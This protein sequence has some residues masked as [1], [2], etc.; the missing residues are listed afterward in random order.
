[1]KKLIWSIM[2]GIA[3]LALSGCGHCHNWQE[4][5]CVSSKLCLEC[6]E[7]QGT[8]T[9]HIWQDATCRTPKTC[10]YCGETDGAPLE[11]IWKAATCTSPKMCA[12]CETT[13]GVPLAHEWQEASCTDPMLCKLCG[14]TEGNAKGHT[15][16]EYKEE[17]VQTCGQDGV[18][19]GV[20][21]VCNQRIV[22]RE[23]ATNQHKIS[24]WLTT[25][26]ATCTQK[27]TQ[28]GVCGVCGEKQQQSLEM[29]AHTDDETWVI[30]S[31]PGVFSE[32]KKATHC[33][34]CKKTMETV[35]FSLSKEEENA[36]KSAQSYLS[37]MSFSR[38]GLIE[39]LEYEGFST[40]VSTFA[41]DSLGANW[42]EQAAKSAKE[43]LDLMSFSRSG[44]IDQ[45]IYE[46]FTR[47]EAEYGVT[48]AG[49]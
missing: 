42:K 16:T 14:K 34:Y 32:G 4:A 39:Q 23:P 21:T 2:V 45:L 22:H 25:K 3:L 1:M 6:G 9:A 13:E 49:Y 31:M 41:V 36:I 46:G 29:L 37:F 20:C 8:P 30:L 7:T 47:E 18:S 28:E 19:S 48:A 27:G 33:I 24:N 5:N 17:Q 10:K 44:L 15:V 38:K 26:E 35:S 11:H 40:E 12:D 43:Y